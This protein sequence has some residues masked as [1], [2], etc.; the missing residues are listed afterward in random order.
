MTKQHFE[1]FAKW[2]ALNT[3]RGTPERDAASRAVMTVGSQF[4][5]RFD[6]GVFMGRVE[7]LTPE[8]SEGQKM[9]ERH[10]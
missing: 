1:A 5:P 6:A 10:Q 3:R 9:V 4:N 8:K 2:I 7:K